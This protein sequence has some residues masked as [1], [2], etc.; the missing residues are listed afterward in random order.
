MLLRHSKRK[1]R[2]ARER[3]DVEILDSPCFDHLR[4]MCVHVLLRAKHARW[5]PEL[6][7]ELC[8][9]LQFVQYKRKMKCAYALLLLLPRRW[10][11]FRGQCVAVEGDVARV[12]MG[13]C[14][15]DLAIVKASCSIVFHCISPSH[16]T[17]SRLARNCWR[18]IAKLCSPGEQCPDGFE[19]RCGNGEVQ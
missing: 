9:T 17:R 15:E 14:D 3:L 2:S 19:R 16:P 6:C 5:Y 13:M 1:Q 12:N 18:T 4:K 7:K 11:E 10:P 8:F